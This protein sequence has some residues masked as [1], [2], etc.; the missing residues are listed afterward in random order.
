VCG[1]LTL[2]TPAEVVAQHFGLDSAPALAPRYNIAPDQPVPVVRQRHSSR[3]RVLEMRLWGLVPH[4]ARQPRTGARLIN[5]RAEGVSERPAFRDA[6]RHRRC[7]I[8]ADGFYEWQARGLPNR[9]PFHVRPANGGLFAIAG[10]YEGW[11]GEE[12]RIDSCTLITTEANARMRSVHDRMPV[13][14]AP[15]VWSAWLDPD[16]RDP[17]PLRA[18]LRPVP[19]EAIE[20]HPVS[21]HVNDPRHDDPEC[22]RAIPDPALF[23]EVFS[24]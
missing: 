8:P 4:W 21:A 1:R 19:A 15:E 6:F 22:L 11:G 12:D 18:L 14:L 5:A 17:E 2:S 13:I 10:L 9:Q 20:L 16:T 7:L 3:E 24:G 23:P